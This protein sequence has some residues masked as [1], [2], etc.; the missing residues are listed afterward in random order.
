MSQ[1]IA[2]NTGHESKNFPWNSTLNTHSPYYVMIQ[3]LRHLRLMIW[4]FVSSCSSHIFTVMECVHLRARNWPFTPHLKI[5][6]VYQDWMFFVIQSQTVRALET[7]QTEHKDWTPGYK[8]PI[9]QRRDC[10]PVFWV[11]CF[12][13]S[14][15]L[16]HIHLYI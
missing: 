9:F 15:P 5:V 1:G 16:S 12:L 6:L 4:P 14:H 11:D 7:Y 8:V 3:W 2:P 13:P 10:V